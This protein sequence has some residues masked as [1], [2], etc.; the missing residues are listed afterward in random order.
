MIL[1]FGK[2]APP[3]SSHHAKKFGLISLVM[4][5]AVA[6]G[7]VAL[8]PY[9]DVHAVAWSGLFGQRDSAS[10]EFRGTP[11]QLSLP[12]EASLSSRSLPGGD[13]GGDGVF[14][15]EIVKSS[16]STKLRSFGLRRLPRESHGWNAETC[17]CTGNANEGGLAWLQ[18]HFQGTGN[19]T[20]VENSLEVWRMQQGGSLM[21]PL[22][23][24]NPDEYDSTGNWYEDEVGHELFN[25][26]FPTNVKK[27]TQTE[28]RFCLDSIDSGLGCSISPPDSDS[29]CG[30]VAGT[31][32]TCYYYNVHT[33]CSTY[34]I[35]DSFTLGGGEVV[36]TVVE[37][38]DNDGH[39]CKPCG[40]GDLDGA[41]ECDNGHFVDPQT[42]VTGCTSECLC[43]RDDGYE[44]VYNTQ[45]DLTNQCVQNLCG[46]DIVDTGED[47]DGGANCNN[48]TC[49]CPAN[50]VSD[51]ARGCTKCGNGFRDA[52]EECDTDLIGCIDCQCN[53]E[54][55]HYP[56]PT[57]GRFCQ[58]HSCPDGTTVCVV[59]G[60][61]VCTCG[62][63]CDGLNNNGE[64]GRI[65]LSESVDEI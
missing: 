42:P 38:G 9:A 35:G 19:L 15:T 31:S 63:T 37:W 3:D 27:V 56:D 43:N 64:Y 1:A 47:C 50:H 18:L 52:G 30:F 65:S 33:S 14:S 55:G 40:N 34:L 4:S 17:Q 49:T 36:I 29:T 45:G 2:H 10:L 57:G 26:T 32:D 11:D 12:D 39:F 51:G 53:E 58:S 25:F 22:P 60:I 6:L 41:E 59:D 7:L 23:P 61:Y 20:L 48:S 28:F 24:N 46:D 44:P 54:E 5:V 13:G 16:P 8:G 21:Y 62:S